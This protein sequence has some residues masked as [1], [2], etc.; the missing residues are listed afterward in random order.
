[1]KH[2]TNV[3]GEKRGETRVGLKANIILFKSNKTIHLGKMPV[4]V[5]FKPLL[6]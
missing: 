3:Q 4:A 5:A 6:I 2:R 1:M